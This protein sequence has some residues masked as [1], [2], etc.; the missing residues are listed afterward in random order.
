MNER[1][2]SSTATGVPPA[3]ATGVLDVHAENLQV[4]DSVERVMEITRQAVAAQAGVGV[5]AASRMMGA[6]RDACFSRT[7]AAVASGFTSCSTASRA[8]GTHSRFA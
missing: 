6:R 8:R 7:V 1:R 3:I 5:G 2:R 4:A